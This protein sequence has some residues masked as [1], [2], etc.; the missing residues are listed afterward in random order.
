MCAEHTYICIGITTY[1]HL[2]VLFVCFVRLKQQ[3]KKKAN[4][5]VN[6]TCVASKQDPTQKR[7]LIYS[8]LCNNIVFNLIKKIV[9]KNMR[10]KNRTETTTT[11]V[12]VTTYI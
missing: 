8:L 12:Q 4:G 7:N 3:K 1:I 2:Y 5:T 11:T 9:Y 6:C 10:T